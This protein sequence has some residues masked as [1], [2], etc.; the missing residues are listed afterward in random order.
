LSATGSGDPITTFDSGDT[1]D[2]EGEE[3]DDGQELDQVQVA[4]IIGGILLY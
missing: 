2:E 4:Q 3:D 1:T